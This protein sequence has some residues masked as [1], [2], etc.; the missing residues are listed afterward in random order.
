MMFLLL[1]LLLLIL[2]QT[3]YYSS[4]TDTRDR[5]GQDRKR[6]K[7]IQK[8]HPQI[9]HYLHL[10]HKKRPRAP[11]TTPKAGAKPQPQK[12]S[13]RLACCTPP[14]QARLSRIIGKS[15]TRLQ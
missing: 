4:A 11:R 9:L 2:N 6:R 8:Y 14:A 3:G 1:L 7:G 10:L 15:E 12:L 13:Q 5:T